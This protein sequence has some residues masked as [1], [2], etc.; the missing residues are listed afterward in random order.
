MKIKLTPSHKDAKFFIP[1]PEKSSKFLPTWFKQIPSHEPEHDGN[2]LSRFAF[3]SSRTVRGCIPFLDAMTGGYTFQLAA[4]VEFSFD[5]GKFVP[6]W[7]VD[8]PLIELQSPTQ[9]MGIPSVTTQTDDIYKWISGWKINTPK[10]YS[11]L[12]THPLNRHDLPFRTFS[13]IV[14]TDKY[15]VNTEFPFQ[16]QA[17][18]S[19]NVILIPKG[20]PI[21]QAIPFKRDS[22]KSS[23]QSYDE[24]KERKNNFNLF[25]KIDRSYKNNFWTKKFFE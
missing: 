14:D 9:A 8:Y 4:D 22:W 23:V 24:I 18:S 17:S 13:G 3:G 7:L 19:E 12:F 5:N 15:Q 21:C 2:K 10:G 20:T 11:T 1:K 16:I 25:S 6:K